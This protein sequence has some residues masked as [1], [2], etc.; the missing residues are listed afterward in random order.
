[1]KYEKR[2]ELKGK[3]EKNFSNL[4]ENNLQK[5]LNIKS[6]E[7]YSGNNNNNNNSFFILPLG[8]F[9]KACC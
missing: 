1:M 4:I 8:K 5:K 9:M 3:N 7:Q 6:N 2:K